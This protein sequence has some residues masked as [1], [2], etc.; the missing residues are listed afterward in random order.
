MIPFSVYGLRLL[1]RGIISFL[2]PLVI[3]ICFAPCALDIQKPAFSKAFIA[4]ADET[5]VKSIGS[6]VK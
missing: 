2:V 1:D 5:S 3:P 6:H 4:R